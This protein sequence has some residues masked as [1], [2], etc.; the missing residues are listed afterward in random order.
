MLEI[1]AEVTAQ[2][3][4]DALQTRV[5]LW[6]VL[7]LRFPDSAFPDE[8]WTDAVN[9]CVPKW[10]ADARMLMSGLVDE[11]REEFMDEAPRF[12]FRVCLTQ[13]EYMQLACYEW[14]RQV[15]NSI[16][17]PLHTYTVALAR[18][19]RH[20]I[21]QLEPISGSTYPLVEELKRSIAF[22]TT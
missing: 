14:N 17:L 15:A 21:H 6:G 12:T 20:L 10:L 8:G 4:R 5:P 7:F 2:A 1:I 3:I 22:F 9:V 11:I 13:R 18:A 16:E 19:G